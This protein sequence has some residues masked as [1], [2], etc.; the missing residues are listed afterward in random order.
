MGALDAVLGLMAGVGQGMDAEK[1]RKMEE[2]ALALERLVAERGL[3]SA[4]QT[5]AL[6]K[7]RR[8]GV[9]ADTAEQTRLTAFSK[10]LEDELIRQVELGNASTAE[11]LSQLI[12]SFPGKQDAR[13]ASTAVDVANA[14]T[15]NEVRPSVVST[16]EA[17]AS[18]AGSNAGLAALTLGDA[19]AS[20]P[21]R[22]AAQTAGYKADRI[23]SDVA[24]EFARPTAAAGLAA[25][26]STTARNVAE[27]AAIPAREARAERTVALGERSAN[28]DDTIFAHT[29]EQDTLDQTNLETDRGRQ[30][31]R[32][33]LDDSYRMR[34]QVLRHQGQDLSEGLALLDF[35]KNPDSA[36]ADTSFILG[37]LG[38]RD[39]LAGRGGAG[40]TPDPARDYARMIS[41]QKAIGVSITNGAAPS[42]K[43]RGS[44]EDIIRDGELTD[45][46][47]TARTDKLAEATSALIASTF[48]EGQTILEGPYADVGVQA[49]SR[50]LTDVR[51]LVS[52]LN[53]RD[54]FDRTHALRN[55]PVG[56]SLELGRFLFKHHQD[57]FNPQTTFGVEDGANSIRALAEKLAGEQTPNDDAAGA[58]GTPELGTPELGTPDLGTPDLSAAVDGQGTQEEP[59]RFAPEPGSGS[60]FGVDGAVGEGISELVKET[61]GGTFKFGSRENISV[62]A[63]SQS[64]G[65]PV[66]HGEV[67]S[68]VQ[69]TFEGIYTDA[70]DR[71]GATHDSISP[72]DR[73]IAAKSVASALG[74]SSQANNNLLESLIQDTQRIADHVDGYTVGAG[75]LQAMME[76]APHIKFQ[77]EFLR[78][79]ISRFVGIRGDGGFEN[80]E[81]LEPDALVESLAAKIEGGEALT[82]L[83]SIENKNLDLYGKQLVGGFLLD[84]EFDDNIMSENWID[85]IAKGRGVQGKTMSEA[86]D[87][88]KVRDILQ[89]LVRRGRFGGVAK[90]QKVFPEGATHTKQLYSQIIASWRDYSVTRRG[91]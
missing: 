16:A 46:W 81:G 59:T 71:F 9:D 66:P 48:R 33:A 56:S 67:E 12:Q 62:A 8:L 53:S 44:I 6:T 77:P 10:R 58:G 24:G 54:D 1:K 3:E 64:G 18:E 85:A 82:T 14:G 65:G 25:T 35:L 51:H 80:Q 57:L 38:N 34:E 70:Y 68:P 90:F 42:G 52:E 79:A 89:D 40:A 63:S 87:E 19:E 11:V 22:R 15:T 69:R 5:D 78:Y 74:R 72:R 91:L 61:V 36:G 75:D 50:I 73:D 39:R 2:E 55:I 60:Q 84:I 30:D 7:S 28:L 76:F 31:A 32:D 86:A 21:D 83:A 47:S 88:H 13:A 4:D 41:I 45:G 17:G 49:L 26:E 20:T 27:T 43:M 23:T 37:F 29:K